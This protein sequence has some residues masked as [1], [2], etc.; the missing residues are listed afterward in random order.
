MD[1]QQLPKTSKFYSRSKKCDFEKTLGVGTTPLVARRLSHTKDQSN[2]VLGNTLLY[3]NNETTVLGIGYV[4]I[5]DQR[6]QVLLMKPIQ[7]SEITNYYNFHKELLRTFFNS[8]TKS[9]IFCSSVDLLGSGGVRFFDMAEGKCQ[10]QQKNKM[11]PLATI[12]INI[13]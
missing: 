5:S 4:I 12:N 10:D 1:P 13:L 9:S 3:R 2:Y 6:Y 7:E 11:S 8:Q